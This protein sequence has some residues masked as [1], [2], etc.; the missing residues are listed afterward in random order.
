MGQSFVDM[1]GQKGV[2][3]IGEGGGSWKRRENKGME[4][5]GNGRRELGRKARGLEERPEDGKNGNK[6]GELE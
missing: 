2:G 5:K 3:E 1:G 4:R 6:E